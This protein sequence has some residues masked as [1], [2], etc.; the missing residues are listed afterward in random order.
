[1]RYY[2]AADGG[3]TKL[4]AI[5]YD[6]DLRIVCSARMSGTI[7]EAR[8]TMRPS[9]HTMRSMDGNEGLRSG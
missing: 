7:P 2:I 4:Q 1:M 6:R 8:S 9:R 3:G 5:L